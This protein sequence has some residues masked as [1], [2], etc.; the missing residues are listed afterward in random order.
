MNCN[1]CKNFGFKNMVIGVLIVGSCFSTHPLKA[2][3][4]EDSISNNNSWDFNA[5]LY[6]C[7]TPGDLVIMPVFDMTKNHLYLQSRFNYESSQTYSFSAG[8][9]FSGGD[10]FSYE[11]TPMMGIMLGNENGFLPGV[12]I[13]LSYGNFNFSS[14]SEYQ[15]NMEHPKLNYVSTWNEFTFYPT[16]WLY[17]GIS[18]Q[19]TRIF[20]THLDIQ[21]G[22]VAG[23]IIN[24]FTFMGYLFNFMDDKHDVFGMLGVNFAFN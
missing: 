6:F 15:I 17:A 2:Q 19:R 20:D 11:F 10:K 5:Q 9:L 13:N 16:D 22:I 12:S 14:D 24:K 7:G 3:Q 23:A 4:R 1:K 21:R 18:V 8:Y